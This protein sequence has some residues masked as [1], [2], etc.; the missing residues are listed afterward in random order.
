MEP[1]DPTSRNYD[2]WLYSLNMLTVAGRVRGG[3]LEVPTEPVRVEHKINA[4]ELCSDDMELRR[5]GTMAFSRPFW[6][7][8]EEL[9]CQMPATPKVLS[10]HR[11]THVSTSVSPDGMQIDWEVTDEPEL[12]KVS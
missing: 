11:R 3:S 9:Q 6:N 4:V 5:S 1:T 10:G 2:L 7:Y 12:R 8:G